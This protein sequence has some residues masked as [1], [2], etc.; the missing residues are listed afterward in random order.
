[1]RYTDTAITFGELPDEITLCIN[2]SNCPYKCKGCHSPY[3]ADDVGELLTITRV[4][5]LI[6][7]NRGISAICFMGGEP[8][9]INQYAK[10][11]KTTKISK[12]AFR[13]TLK[14]DYT[15]P[16]GIELHKGDP[17]IFKE[18]IPNPLKV[19]WYT[20]ASSIPE[21]INLEYFD[22]IK[23]G[24]YIEELGPLNS[25]TT[26]QRLYRVDNGRLIDITYKFWK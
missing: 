8:K 17:L 7:E 22:Y 5:S 15:L 6:K 23:V 3:L 1:M 10:V 26:N 18:Y 4:E 24:P 25:I 14:E 19:G 16:K 11:I 20:G 12:E 21:E 13:I 9:E 2:I